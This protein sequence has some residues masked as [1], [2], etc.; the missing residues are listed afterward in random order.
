[1]AYLLD[2]YMKKYMDQYYRYH[3]ITAGA[4]KM[5]LAYGWPGNTIQM[6]SFCERMILTVGRRTITEEY[7]KEL[8]EELYEHTQ[9]PDYYIQHGLTPPGS[10][11]AA[12]QMQPGQGMPNGSCQGNDHRNPSAVQWEQNPYSQKDGHQHHHIVEKNEALRH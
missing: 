6:R 2:S 1:M 12:G 4:R 9:E 7:V 5:L 10:Q 8:L 11:D 3:A